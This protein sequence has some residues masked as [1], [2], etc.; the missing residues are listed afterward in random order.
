[1]KLLQNFS[2]NLVQSLL[3]FAVPEAQHSKPALRDHGAARRVKLDSVC[4][5]TAVD[6]DDEAGH[7]A[8]KV[9]DVAADWNLPAKLES[10]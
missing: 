10:A 6:L 9:D 1:M 8:Y 2:Q 3:H 4:M 7:N 5:L